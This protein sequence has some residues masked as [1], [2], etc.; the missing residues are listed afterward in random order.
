MITQF[1]WSGIVVGAVY[2][3]VAIGFTMIYNATETVN[4]AVGESL[5]IGAYLILTFYKIY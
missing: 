3:L 4:F 2:A 5:M 1:I